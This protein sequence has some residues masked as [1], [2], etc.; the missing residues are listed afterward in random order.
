MSGVITVLPP[1]ITVFINEIHY[2]ND[3]TDSN[4]GIEIAG[5][6][7]TDLSCYELLFY[8]GADSLQDPSVT[9]TGTIP[10]QLCG[11]GTIWFAKSGIQNGPRD[12]V[13]LLNTCSGSVIQFLSW[14]GEMMAL[15]GPAMGMTSV[16]IGISEP[17]CIGHSLQLI[18]TGTEYPDFT[19]V[20]PNAGSEGFINT[21]QNFCASNSILYFVNTAI[22][23][24]EGAGVVAIEVAIMDPS[25]TDTVTV[26][27]AYS[28]GTATSGSDFNTFSTDTLIF[29]PSST[30]SQ[31]ITITII[32]DSDLLEVPETIFLML[33]NPTNV[34]IVSYNNIQTITIADNDFPNG[35][36]EN[37]FFSEYIEGSSNN[38]AL[39]IYNPRMDSVDLSTYEVRTYSSG[40]ICGTYSLNLSGMLAPGDV[41]VISH[42]SAS[43]T[44]ITSES[45]ITS[46]VTFFGGDDAVG[47]YQ[48]SALIDVIGEIGT[49]PGTNWPVGSGFTSNNTLVRK[50]SVNTGTIDW[51][52]GASQWDVYT[53][54][55][56]TFIGSHTMIPCPPITASFSH[57]GSI[58]VG[59]SVC[60]TDL[61]TTL[62]T[63]IVQWCWDYGDGNA[64]CGTDQNPCHTYS[65]A[66]TYTVILAVTDDSSN[67]DSFSMQV[68]VAPLAVV[69]AG[70]DQTVCANDT[71]I[72]LSGSVTVGSST[73][74][75]TTSGSGIFS[76][77][78]TDFTAC[79]IPSTSDTTA[80]SVT[81]T[82]TSTN[83]GNC[84]TVTDV[85][86]ITFYQSPYINTSSVVID[87]STCGNN[88]GNVTGITASGGM[89]TL[90][91][92]WV[93]AAS[94][95]VGSAANLTLVVSDSY[96]L[97]VSDSTGC[98]S[99]VG[100]YVIADK[101]TPAAPTATSPAAYCDGAT[102]ADLT[103]S[104]SG[105]T[106]Y[107]SSN[108]GMTDTLGTGS[109][110]TS[111]VTSTDTFY[112]AELGACIGP[113]T[114]VVITVNSAIVI[115]ASADDSICTGQ[116]STISVSG[117]GGITP[118][119]FTWNNGLGVGSNF[120][121][122]PTSTTTYGVTAVD[123]MGC[124]SNSDSVTV[125]V[126]PPLSISA[127]GTGSICSG[128]VATL[129][130]I[131]SGGNGGPYSYSWSSGQ[132]TSSITVTPTTTTTYSVGVSD[133]C[134]PDV[135]DVTTVTVLA[136]P[137]A[138]FSSATTMLDVVFTD[139]STIS[140]GTIVD[141]DWGFDD[142]FN[143]TQQNPSHTYSSDGTYNVCLTVTSAD[144]CF[145]ST[146]NSVTVS[147][148]GI[149][150]SGLDVEL[151]IFPN[152]NN[153][154]LF[155]LQM[156]NLPKETFRVA[157]YNAIG[158]ALMQTEYEINQTPSMINLRVHGPGIYYLRL[159]NKSNNIN[160]KIIF[161]K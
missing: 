95:S 27:V 81:I 47:L 55:S 12:A 38:K 28:S 23:V 108:A 99:M 66:A 115:T 107:W 22:D 72:S 31:F 54:N 127:F 100:P 118:Y 142:G 36:C 101:G 151:N 110:F 40:A 11:F 4:E 82:L 61:S 65:T 29:P 21:M 86:T 159:T 30:T 9:L 136:T 140:S 41:Y 49:D 161:I 158:E 119:T 84:S 34:G 53:L 58:C 144:G 48:N 57:S 131:A 71:C 46:D 89:G 153:S 96:T 87:S 141:W 103:A 138:I 44:A 149:N 70:L 7:G 88:D 94:S 20:G 24:S 139:A 85:A 76:P 143:S 83:N 73:G 63:S 64:V 39:E 67:V 109:P 8:N 128:D 137:V 16:D 2:D 25:A 10:D 117:S 92:D 134:S 112:V 148:V 102:I 155:Y 6:A 26:E 152:P 14:E 5:P 111:G 50:D 126:Y 35:P 18:G 51:S 45:D 97:T 120:T 156:K 154:G 147:S 150:E 93:N 160:R 78:D 133:G 135:T 125:V 33:Q 132:T 43:L 19:W 145:S 121:V 62:S 56:T 37:L 75:W 157:V 130:V 52:I 113:A 1:P 77:S 17:G 59:D 42:A 13:G 91:Y 3:G 114:M 80:G 104:G 123:G 116:S 68:T 124:A 69:D 90:T 106:L 105:G 15:D 60:F 122:T 129:S 98:S 79:Y 146:C 74:I 32:D